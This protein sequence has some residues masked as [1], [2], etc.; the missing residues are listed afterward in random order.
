MKRPAAKDLLTPSAI[1]F[2][3]EMA[4]RLHFSPDT[5]IL[6]VACGTAAAECYIASIHRCPMTVLD[7]DAARIMEAQ[8]RIRRLRL[9][10]LVKARTGDGN[11][12]PFPD[13]RFD[14]VVALGA[15]TALK[16]HA[17]SEMARVTKLGG[18]VA[19]GDIVWLSP[20]IPSD[21]RQVW[22]GVADRI[23]TLF[24]L[25]RRLTAAG[26]NVTYAESFDKRDWWEEYYKPR[27][28]LPA[29]AEEVRCYRRYGVR[30]LGVGWVTGVKVTPPNREDESQP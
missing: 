23:P 26:L 4:R 11:N 15:L 7:I 12:L 29:Y 18:I 25:V 20:H 30:Y 3:E 22:A 8:Q 5:H 19:V 21:L 14:V 1:P 10:H 9:T 24:G 28:H 27:L 6:S 2:W 16:N 17:L 13:E